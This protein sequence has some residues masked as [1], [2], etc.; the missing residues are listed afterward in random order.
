MLSLFVCL[1]VTKIVELMFFFV[2]G[3]MTSLILTL[4]V[5]FNAI[6]KF[7]NIYEIVVIVCLFVCYQDC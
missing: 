1:F 6:F 3:W 2:T 5:Q 7:L 4:L